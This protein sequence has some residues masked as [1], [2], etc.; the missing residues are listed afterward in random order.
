MKTRLEPRGEGLGDG[1]FWERGGESTW[2]TYPMGLTLAGVLTF[3]ACNRGCDLRVMAVGALARIAMAN[4][5]DAHYDRDADDRAAY[6]R[7]PHPN[8]A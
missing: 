6:R 2:R 4:Q 3:A 7:E 8:R 5:M 1:W